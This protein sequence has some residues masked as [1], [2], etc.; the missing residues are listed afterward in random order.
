M[1]PTQLN[2]E[3]NPPA[4]N[5]LIDDDENHVFIRM[6][7]DRSMG[8]T[9]S[10]IYAAGGIAVLAVLVNQAIHGWAALLRG[11]PLT[12]MV[13]S[14]FALSLIMRFI[15]RRATVT[16]QA[17]PAGIEYAS[18]EFAARV[19]GR[20]KIQ[21]IFTRKTNF[22]KEITLGIR[23]HDGSDLVIGTG[24]EKEIAAMSQALHRVL[25]SAPGNGDDRVLKS[26]PP[27][28]DERHD[29]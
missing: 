12:A 20:E 16:V 15:G 4:G 3:R 25:N 22:S 21:R 18:G 19:I 2:Y 17:T 5:T 1:P 7:P 6:L 26:A 8:R 11:A 28:G 23:L 24:T 14:L 13:G 27:T 10:W 29:N 9:A